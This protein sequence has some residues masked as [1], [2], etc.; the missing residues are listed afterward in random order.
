MRRSITS[1]HNDISATTTF[2]EAAMMVGIAWR[3]KY[4]KVP[5]PA[6]SHALSD[7]DGT[8]WRIACA[9]TGGLI[10]V[11]TDNMAVLAEDLEDE[12]VA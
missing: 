2:K 6:L 11:V 3:R 9:E 4:G 8:A 7:C 5:A 1:N 12:Q 10:A